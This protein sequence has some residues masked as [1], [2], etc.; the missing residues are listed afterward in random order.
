MYCFLNRKSRDRGGCNVPEQTAPLIFK[1]KCFLKKWAQ[2][3]LL[4]S[5]LGNRCPSLPR[6]IFLWE[7]TLLASTPCPE[8]K[9]YTAR[10][11]PKATWRNVLFSLNVCSSPY[12]ALLFS[13]QRHFCIKKCKFRFPLV[14]WFLSPLE[15]IP[16]LSRDQ[17]FFPAP[18]RILASYSQSIPLSP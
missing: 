6:D 17:P 5:V 8:I 10:P 11:Y 12:L 9:R 16:A 4:E 2:G 14:C 18:S 13:E 7:P 15:V 3:G 1:K